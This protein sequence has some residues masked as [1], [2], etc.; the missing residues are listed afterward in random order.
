MAL[1]GLYNLGLGALASQQASI[2]AT[3]RN[4]ANVNTP[5]YRRQSADLAAQAGG[6]VQTLGFSRADDATLSRRERT[7]EGAR[8]GA[9]SLS[10]ALDGLDAELGP[11]HDELVG[12][13]AEMFGSFGALAAAPTDPNLRTDAVDRAES[14]A[15]SLNRA[16]STLSRARADA[17]ADIGAMARQATDLA[18][19]VAAGNRAVRLDP[20][21]P[22]L[23]DQR[24][25]A[26][27]ELS[28]MIGGTARIDPDGM[29]RVV[30]ASGAS[31]VDGERASQIRATP[32]AARGGLSRVEVVDGA[33]VDDVTDKLDGGQIGGRLR[34]RDTEASQALAGLDRLASDL[35]GAINAVHSQN[36]GLDGVTGRDLFT[37][38]SAATIVVSAAVAADHRL[39]ASAAAG[40]GPGDTSGLAALSA[41]RD[42][43]LGGGGTST[44]QEEAIHLGAQL[45]AAT[46]TARQTLS[47]EQGRSDTLAAIRDSLS[48]VSPEEELTKLS[49]LQH[50]HEAT[51]RF[52]STVDDMLGEMIS[53][54]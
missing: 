18:S 48:G 5:G 54:L 45:G 17:D 31:I 52:I 21:D 35:G 43:R 38:S 10:T 9:E 51:V 46:R 39:L 19:A 1:S 11:I 20:S 8:A 14:V 28:S 33:H 26:A 15:S 36:A 12:H 47:L 49:Q 3:S 7:R 16:A 42:A 44:F 22:G 53:R 34:F 37:G 27:Q 50:A 4:I 24:D 29:M 30:L 2:A 23:A 25:R 32:D 13:V 6:G 40:A 41:L